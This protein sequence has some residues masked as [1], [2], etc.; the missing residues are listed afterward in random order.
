MGGAPLSASSLVARLLPGV[1]LTTGQLAQMRALDARHHTAL[2][3][4]RERARS[5]GRAWTG[6]TAAEERAMRDA[7]VDAV[8]GMLDDDQRALFDRNLAAE[9]GEAG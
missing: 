3:A 4:L 6:P 7:L 5:E 8:R 1:A 9:R 2:F